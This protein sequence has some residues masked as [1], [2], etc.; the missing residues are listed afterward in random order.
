MDYED[1][2]LAVSGRQPRAIHVPSYMLEDPE[3]LEL[4]DD[5]LRTEFISPTKPVTALSRKDMI[6]A[7]AAASKRMN[8]PVAQVYRY[9]YFVTLLLV[10]IATLVATNAMINHSVSGWFILL[11][12][13]LVLLAME[14]ARIRIF[15]TQS[16]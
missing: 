9:I 13:I 7:K 16:I 2:Q 8:R 14:I 11:L 3:P 1:E 15:Y 12:W 6:I 4:A 10:L 5:F